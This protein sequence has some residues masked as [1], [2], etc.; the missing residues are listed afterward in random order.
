MEELTMTLQGLPTRQLIPEED[1]LA[2]LPTKGTYRA[3]RYI[4]K[5]INILM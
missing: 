2:G 1:G 3:F 5:A 4:D